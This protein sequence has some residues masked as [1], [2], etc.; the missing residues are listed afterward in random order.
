MN[1]RSSGSILFSSAILGFSQ[2]KEAE[3]CAQRTVDHYQRDLRLWL[4]FRGD[5]PLEPVEHGEIARYLA[6]LRTE[7]V[8]RRITGGNDRRLSAKSIRNVWGSLSSFFAWLAREFNLPDPMDRIPAPKFQKAEVLPFTREQIEGLLKVCDRSAE[9]GTLLRKRFTMTRTTAVRDRALIK[10][11]L[12]TGMRANELCQL[13]VGDYD[14]QTGDI[15][16]RF[17]KGGKH[18]I[19][20]L[21]KNARRDLWRYL[22]RRE[23]A[24][25][26][27][28]PLFTGRFDRRMRNDG[29]RHLLIRLG[30]RAGVPNCHP[31]RFRHT[32]A[33]EFLRSGGDVFSLQKLLGHS[34]LD[35]VRHYLNLAQVDVR[36][37]HR[38]ASPV[39]NWR[40]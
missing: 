13:N 40:L 32:F 36:N 34:T 3:G 12:D 11:L 20:Y 39:D 8:P 31:H 1:Q 24:N 2:S 9:A 17:G 28:A 38:R 14:P 29:L 35:M 15:R 26:P 23:D 4:S 25:D 10:V 5:G 18:R 6:Y 16:V 7:Y 30:R 37:A 21:E 22:A 27:R 33:L 19:V